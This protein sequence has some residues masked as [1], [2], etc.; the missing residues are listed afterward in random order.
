MY[1]AITY[2]KTQFSK[3]AFVPVYVSVVRKL[4]LKRIH[5]I[6]PPVAAVR[7]QR[8]SDWSQICQEMQSVSLWVDRTISMVLFH[9][10]KEDL[11][12]VARWYIF[13]TKNPSL[14]RYVFE[15][16]ANTFVFL[17][18]VCYIISHFGML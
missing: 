7:L 14:S 17:M 12:R 8:K 2:K 13:H 10:Q 1:L 6:G 3:L 15:G 18:D 9:L 4:R 11:A 16:F 5:R